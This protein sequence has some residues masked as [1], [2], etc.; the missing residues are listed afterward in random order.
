MGFKYHW[1]TKQGSKNK[2]NWDF[3]GIGLR[4]N[5]SLCIV[6]DGSSSGKNSGDFTRQIATKLIDW[7]ITITSPLTTACVITQLFEIQKALIPDFK[8]ASASYAIVL[9]ESGEP[10]MVLHAGD[11]LVGRYNGSPPVCWETK[12]HTLANAIKSMPIAEIAKSP[13]RNR[14][15]RSLRAKEFCEPESC[16]IDLKADSEIIVC[17]DGFWADLEHREQS[18]FLEGKPLRKKE[19]DDCS[20]LEISFLGVGDT[21]TVSSETFQNLYIV[22]VQ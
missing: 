8:Y 6:L 4:P 22:D 7:F 16:T 3:C 17:T 20:T 5:M 9:I 18:K 10:P 12:P 1:R 11:C 14:L 21:S 2:D 13:L 15:T 19:D